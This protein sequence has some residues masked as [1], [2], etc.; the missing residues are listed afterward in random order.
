MMLPERS[1]QTIRIGCAAAVLLFA[2][3]LP[4]RS[5]ELERGEWHRV[6]ESFACKVGAPRQLPPSAVTPEA[7]LLAC[8]HMGPF[9]IGGDAGT[10]ESVLGPP[11]RT[12][13]QPKEALVWFLGERDHYPYFVASVRNDK[14]VVL[15]VTGTAHSK[16][17]SF[18]H[19]NLGDS[20]DT[21]IK[22]FGPAFR[23]GKSDLPDTDVWHYGPWPF[24]F[25]VKGGKV[26]SIRIVDPAP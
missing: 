17:Y 21:L 16:A 15:Q 3:A 12:L 1:V 20:T 23:V 26:T 19:V 18:N 14:I 4:A 13:T 6:G 7:L 24:S 2:A 11:H 5:V 8:M 22:F 10:L 25:E 9:V